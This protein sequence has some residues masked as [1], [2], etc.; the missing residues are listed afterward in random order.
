MELVYLWIENYK[1]IHKQGFNFS[2][3]FDCKFHDKYDEN[4]KLEDN[5][6]LNI[7]KKEEDEYI[8][9]FF[10]ENINVTAIVGKNGSGKS[11][12]SEAL[13][14]GT[15]K[16]YQSEN[17][18]KIFSIL[19]K[20]GIFYTVQSGISISIFLNDE[21]KELKETNDIF[22]LHSS[23]A[24][25]NFSNEFCFN[26]QLSEYCSFM[27]DLE[28]T[29]ENKNF[30]SFP[31]KTNDMIDLNKI[32]LLNN[33]YMLHTYN[34]LGKESIQD[35]L[36]NLDKSKESNLHFTPDKFQLH[37]D[38][39]KTYLKFIDNHIHRELLKHILGF[40]YSFESFTDERLTLSSIKKLTVYYILFRFVEVDMGSIFS[41]V[42]EQYF[43]SH[44]LIVFYNNFK[45]RV[46]N[47]KT[48]EQVD[49][50]S[51]KIL[52][53]FVE[54][55]NS[56]EEIFRN[57]NLERLIG[58]LI[59]SLFYG[60]Y[61]A[62][63]YYEY[64]IDRKENFQHFRRRKE[65]TDEIELLSN[66]PYFIECNLWTVTSDGKEVNFKS[67]SYGE[68]V[69]NRMFYAIYKIGL[70][71]KDKNYKNLILI[72]DE[73]ENGLHP[74]WQRK[75][76]YF[77]DIIIQNL[78]SAEYFNSIQ[79][80]PITH[81]SFLLSD[82]PRKN[83]LVLGNNLITTKETFGENIH[84]L[85]SDSFFMENGLMGEFAKNKIQEIIDYLN[86]KKTIEEISTKKEQIKQVIES[87]GEDLLRMKLL[88]MYYQKFEIDELEREKQQLIEQQNEITKRIKS[89]EDKQKK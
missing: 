41:E 30:F 31:D 21:E 15:T 14:L 29:D 16:L 78:V 25:D 18:F 77:I 68:K 32:N 66:L 55:T 72:F 13:I 11:S 79:F 60:I 58:E 22:V 20:N 53:E 47:F 52:D 5:C 73:V 1:N 19:E 67:L 7:I 76:F 4:R 75:F 74:E 48:L 81:S 69:I 3:R 46:I 24:L 70:D 89:I 35:L 62:L 87:I 57:S 42:N 54:D 36:F 80:I 39:E 34:T 56:F 85:L 64:I 37:F 10:G 61:S 38:F 44:D 43:R 82:I 28:T 88:D 86:D 51:A 2:P 40:Q 50:I 12:V 63:C 83:I 59:K 23:N 27:Y 45:N 84:T 26:T 49:N 33:K 8:K 6:K 9:D 71:V 17:E 65:V